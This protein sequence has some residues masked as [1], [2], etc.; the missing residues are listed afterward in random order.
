[1]QKATPVRDSL[2][3]CNRKLHPIAEKHC[4]RRCAPR[5]E[6]VSCKQHRSGAENP[7]EPDSILETNI[8]K[9]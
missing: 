5:G 1:M 6:E 2:F 9:F 4:V 3:F 7:S 8:K